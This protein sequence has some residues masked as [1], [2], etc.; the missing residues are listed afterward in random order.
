MLKLNPSKFTR[1]G[2]ITRISI[3]LALF[4]LLFIPIGLPYRTSLLLENNSIESLV[5]L[6]ILNLIF[7][8]YS[9]SL[10]S[11][12]LYESKIGFN[13]FKNYLY[14]FIIIAIGLLLT[15]F[16]FPFEDNFILFPAIIGLLVMTLISLFPLTEMKS[17]IFSPHLTKP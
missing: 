10:V 14:L 17:K 15:Y 4:T 13:I 16:I 8:T 6:Y 12:T 9:L 3:C 1:F 2:S 5:P 7:F 11:A